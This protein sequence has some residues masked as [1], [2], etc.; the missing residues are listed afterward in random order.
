MFLYSLSSAAGSCHHA[1]GDNYHQWH[2][3]SLTVE[4]KHLIEEDY[5]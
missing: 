3:G 1:T 2:G 4:V 5:F